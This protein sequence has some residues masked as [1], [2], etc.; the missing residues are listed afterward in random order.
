MCD[1]GRWPATRLRLVGAPAEREPAERV[2]V[3]GERGK[4]PGDRARECATHV[5]HGEGVG[6]DLTPTEIE[7]DRR[8]SL[9]G[10]HAAR[11]L[12]HPRPERKES[13]PREAPPALGRCEVRGTRAAVGRAATKVPW[14][15][16]AVSEPSTTSASYA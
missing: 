4:A 2:E 10:E 11:E 5:V 13:R 16:W 9:R 1:A 8:V 14:P 6:G 7:A 15:T 3:N 12:E